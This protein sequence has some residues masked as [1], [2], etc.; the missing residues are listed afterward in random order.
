VIQSASAISLS[1]Q[2]PS[3]IQIADNLRRQKGTRSFCN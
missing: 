1:F 3:R 2:I